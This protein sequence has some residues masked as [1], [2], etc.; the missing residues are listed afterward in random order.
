MCAEISFV[1]IL[2]EYHQHSTVQ[3]TQKFS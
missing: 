2:C 3:T 1:L